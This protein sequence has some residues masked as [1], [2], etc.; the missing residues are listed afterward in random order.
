MERKS[1]KNILTFD[2]PKKAEEN[3]I[4]SAKKLLLDKGFCVSDP[5]YVDDYSNNIPSLIE[6]FYKKMEE[7]YPSRKVRYLSSNKDKIFV[8]NLLKS[9][10]SQ[11][12][13]KE[14]AYQEVRDIIEC[15]FNYEDAIGLF[16]P[17][18]SISILSIDWIMKKVVGVLNGEN[19]ISNDRKFSYYE[20]K[21]QSII[22]TDEFKQKVS[23][24]LDFLFRKVV[25][26]VDEEES[27]RRS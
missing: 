20:D 12:I 24:E 4:E 21:M 13:S 26:N 18:T 22:D 14:R 15:L 27:K 3:S 7:K 25:T 19:E 9:R 16:E 8:S 10:K 5:I 17:I 1:K 6:F 23:E 2:F 11:G